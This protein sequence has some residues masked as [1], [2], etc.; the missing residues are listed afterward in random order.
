MA[1]FKGRA[2][3]LNP[4]WQRTN[5]GPMVI[6]ISIVDGMAIPFIASSVVPVA[7]VKRNFTRNS[8]QY[9]FDKGLDFWTA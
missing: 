8:W 5:K 9:P 3:A 4:V 2:S 1:L 6:F 7:M